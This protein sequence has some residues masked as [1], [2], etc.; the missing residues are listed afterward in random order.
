MAETTKQYC[1]RVTD[2]RVD[3]VEIAA[4]KFY[5]LSRSTQELIR[6]YAEF[7]NSGKPGILRFEIPVYRWQEIQAAERGVA[8]NEEVS[9]G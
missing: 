6:S 7:K 3:T 1:G 5:G 4:S 9:R 8:R 2:F